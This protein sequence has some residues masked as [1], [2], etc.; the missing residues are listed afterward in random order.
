MYIKNLYNEIKIWVKIRKIAQ[1]NKN[2]LLE[3]GFR[4]DWV[5][6]IYTVINLPEEVV[7][8]PISQEGYVLMQLREHDK[9]FLDLG[10]ADYVSPEFNPIP[11]TDSFLL[12]LSADREYLKVWPIIVSAVKTTIGLLI[13]RV[14]YILFESYGEKISELW[15]KMTSLLF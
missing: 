5:G 8:A 2:K 10:I 12:V 14:I 7:S 11:N 4:V 1:E 13:L 15:N 3:K 6:R 9:L